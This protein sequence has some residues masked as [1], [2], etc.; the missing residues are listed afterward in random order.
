[1]HHKYNKN[2]LRQ[3]IGYSKLILWRNIDVHRSRWFK[4]LLKLLLKGR[5]SAD[6]MCAVTEQDIWK[7]RKLIQ[8]TSLFDVLQ[9][10]LKFNK[11]VLSYMTR[12][13]GNLIIIKKRYSFV[14][15]HLCQRRRENIPSTQLIVCFGL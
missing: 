1:M 2:W 15:S 6:T 9:L 13:P 3:K 5:R 10:H 7:K 8:N 4:V 14:H 11:K 12:A